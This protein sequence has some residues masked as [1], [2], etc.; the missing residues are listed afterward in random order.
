MKKKLLGWRF[1]SQSFVREN[2]DGLKLKTFI[3]FVI[4]FTAATS[5]SLTYW[6]PNFSISLS[7]PQG[8]RA[9]FLMKLKLLLSTRVDLDLLITSAQALTL[10]SRRLAGVDAS[11]LVNA[12]VVPSRSVL[13]GL[14]LSKD[15]QS[16]QW[17]KS[18]GG[19]GWKLLFV[20]N[21]VEIF[22]SKQTKEPMGG[23]DGN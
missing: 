5:T 4:F 9:F 21:E 1:E 3:S 8:T 10:T 17:T 6:I 19:C 12:T 14:T 23:R 16:R 20:E 7:Q 13:L 11:Y 22:I 2:V 15:M 18:K